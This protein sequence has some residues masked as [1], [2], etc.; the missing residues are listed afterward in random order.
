MKYFYFVVIIFILSLINFNA[1]L[2]K[3]R[4]IDLTVKVADD[5]YLSEFS[6][7][8]ALLIGVSDYSAGWDDLQSIPN[9]INELESVLQ[10]QGF[11]TTKVTDPTSVELK[12]KLEEFIL[13][14]GYNKRNRLLF[15][16]SGHGFTAQDSNKSYLVPVDAPLP[17][18]NLLNFK[19]RSLDLNQIMSWARQIEARHALFMF[20]SCF[21][22][23]V[24]K[25]RGRISPLPAQIK[26]S[27]EN[28]VRQFITAGNVGEQVPARSTFIK[29]LIDSLKYGHAD[30]NNDGFM[31]GS[32]LGL[33]LQQK[34]PQFETQTPQ[35]GK[36][37][38]YEL[39]RGDFIFPVISNQK[40]IPESQPA[41]FARVKKRLIKTAQKVSKPKL[42][43]SQ[44]ANDQRE[45]FYSMGV[46]YHKGA[47]VK[48]N[49]VK[50]LK[51]YQQ[52]ADL[53]HAGAMNNIGLFYDYGYGVDKDDELALNWY[54]KAA[55]RNDIHAMVNLAD[56]Y[57]HGIA[58][59]K[60]L[61]LAFTWYLKAA[62]AGDHE[63]MN[64]V[65]ELYEN[66]LGTHQNNQLA[67]KWYKKSAADGNEMALTNIAYMYENGQGVEKD[68]E[69]ALQWYKR[70]ANS[71]DAVS[72]SNIAYLYENG[73]G[74]SQDFETAKYW[75]QKAAEKGD[76][77]S[78]NKL[79]NEFTP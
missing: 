74:V 61:T 17:S 7:N 63:A 27:L 28:P 52:A 64:H 13:N 76:I 3:T 75:Y 47:N 40:R 59:K 1:V 45:Y 48:Q 66:G 43:T 73:M 15:F 18:H 16:Y 4:G 32:E 78:K 33:Y 44:T 24:F 77:Y 39:S 49:Y 5:Y 68:Y 22:G 54:Q 10:S 23:A 6:G 19:K 30:L 37:R 70:A 60:D 2:A 38:D 9:E 79:M 29:V 62:K 8:Y 67:I 53:G 65:G 20:D 35:Y 34:V 71:G 55:M 46:I 72:M 21:S 14:Y 26:Y 31:S 25:Q 57:E 56:F 11:N 51:W 12:A 36:I 50:A 69:V 42:N 41:Q 58:T